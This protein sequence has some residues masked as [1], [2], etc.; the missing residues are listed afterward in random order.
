MPDFANTSPFGPVLTAMV[1]PFNTEG[2]V[3]YGVAEKLADHLIRHGSD[4]LVVCGTTGES[5]TLSWA[6]EH[7]LFR[8]I[9]RAVGDRC[10]VIAGTGS[11][12]TQEAMEATQ[13][14]AKLGVDGSLQVVPYY[15]KPPQAGLY[16][17]FEAI[18]AAAPDLPMMLYNIPGRTGQSLTP[19]TVAQLA[20]INNIVAIKEAT[21]SLEQASQIRA[22][23]PPEFAL[24]AGDDLLTLP[25]LAVGASGVV[26]VASHLVGD[27]LQQMIQHFQ[28]GQ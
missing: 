3:D 27:R 7:E 10:S 4:G 17:H 28:A 5:P 22:L 19:E 6:E 8:V 18:A 24:Y 26:S 16:A 23:T 9:K 13:I 11:N 21:G 12:C 14:A 15:N 2:A 25:L 20:E 1:T